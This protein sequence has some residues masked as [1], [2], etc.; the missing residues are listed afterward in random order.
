LN[1]TNLGVLALPLRR[2]FAYIFI[3]A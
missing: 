2:L 1:Q 3:D